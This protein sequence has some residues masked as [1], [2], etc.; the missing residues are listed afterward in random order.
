MSLIWIEFKNDLE[1]LINNFYFFTL[2]IKN[3]SVYKKLVILVLILSTILVYF[4]LIT[5][6]YWLLF[7]FMKYIFLFLD[8]IFNNL[9]YKLYRFNKYLYIYINIYIWS[10]LVYNKINGL[11][12]KWTLKIYLLSKNGL[13]M[14]FYIYKYY[15]IIKKSIDIKLYNSYL[16]L[17]YLLKFSYIIIWWKFI[18]KKIKIITNYYK[19][20]YKIYSV[21]ILEKT[22]TY[23]KKSY[24]YYLY[25]KN[26]S[27]SIFWLYFFKIFMKFLFLPK[28]YCNLYFITV[29]TF[30]N[31]IIF[32]EYKRWVKLT[33]KYFNNLE[34]SHVKKFFHRFYLL[35][36]KWFILNF[37]YYIFIII[38]YIIFYINK[39]L[40]EYIYSWVI[41]E[42]KVYFFS[43]INYLYLLQ[44]KGSRLF[45]DLVYQFFTL[46]LSIYTHYKY[47]AVINFYFF[48]HL[49]FGYVKYLYFTYTQYRFFHQLRIINFKYCYGKNLKKTRL[50]LKEDKYQLI[51]Q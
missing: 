26:I 25:I 37:I 11:K 22:K 35:M 51:I 6:S 39:Y 46:Y 30:M 24:L 17:E 4:V 34:W 14:K 20:Y 38:Y 2:W 47:D 15:K 36:L 7:F 41:Y 8:V 48:K 45:T 44:Y 49:I 3:L 29:I 40:F 42:L 9:N 32:L 33:M 1:E 5:I 12:E 16:K 19:T 31:N 28:L 10:K 21:I 50:I 13:F 18:E 27:R 23:R 43:W